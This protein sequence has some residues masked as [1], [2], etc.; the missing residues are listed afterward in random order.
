MVEAA[1][2]VVKEITAALVHD[3][4]FV[5]RYCAKAQT[6]SQIVACRT[7]TGI[8]LAADSIAFDVDPNRETIEA[9]INRIETIL[10][11]KPTESSYLNQ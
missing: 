1:V 10:I 8:I 4:K 11:V 6:M 5:K 2:Q 7:G 3:N 9:K